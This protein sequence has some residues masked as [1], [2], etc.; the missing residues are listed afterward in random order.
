MRLTACHKLLATNFR[1][2]SQH[3]F[4][5][6]TKV[7]CLALFATIPHLNTWIYTYLFKSNIYEC[8]CV[9]APICVTYIGVYVRVCIENVYHCLGVLKDYLLLATVFMVLVVVVVVVVV[10]ILYLVSACCRL[11]FYV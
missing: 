2:N 8:V 3:T 6:F 11:V 9:Y 5:N 1:L 4:V 7:S 10:Q